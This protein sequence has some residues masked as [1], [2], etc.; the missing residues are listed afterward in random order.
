MEFLKRFTLLILLSFCTFYAKAQISSAMQKAFQNSY[1]HEGKKQYA[2]AISDIMPFYNER[3]YE[4][5]L[6]IGWLYYLSKNYTSSQQY[7][8]RAVT[9]KPSSIEAKFG[10]IQPLSLLGS[11]DRV[12]DQ[13][14]NIIKI[15]SQ[16]TQANYWIGVLLYN[17]KQYA[18]AAKYFIKVVSIYPFDYDSNHMLGWANLFLGKKA[19]A[20]A[21]FELALLIKPGDSSSTDG[22]NRS[23]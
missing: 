10:L 15:D 13:Y 4:T 23:K 11:W 20:K 8:G 5:N 3:N 21:C 1:T 18:T 22:L 17:R 16:N 19:E 2:E 6:R 9:I 12:L 14:N 7:Y